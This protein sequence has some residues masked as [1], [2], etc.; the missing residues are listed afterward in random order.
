MAT[1]PTVRLGTV[2]STQAVAFTLAAD[3]TPDRTVVVADFQAAGR[4][5]RGRVWHAEAGTSLLA[6]IVVRPRLVLAEMPLYSFA[7][8]LAVAGAVTRLTGAEPR[9]KW[10]NDVLLDG[11]KV[12]GILL[13]SRTSGG[14]SPVV[15][16]GIGLNLLQRTFPDGVRDRATSLALATGV[17]VDRDRA[18]DALLDE[19]D[20][21]RG[22]LEADGFA[23]LRARWLALGATVGRTVTVD[24]ITGRAVDLATDG[25]LVV[26]DG[27]ALRRVLAGE[28]TWADP[29]SGDT[30]ADHAA[31]R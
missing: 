13:E 12:S 11:R 28:V 8:A 10:P 1:P 26:D 14:A 17:T 21:W 20:T 15:V 23:A 25:A 3:G 16:I 30:A 7:A 6:S 24:G 29:V 2:D 5:R 31:R 22:R 9:L 19:F 18:L 4:G 27:V